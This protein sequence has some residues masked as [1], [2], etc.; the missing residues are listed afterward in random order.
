MDIVS[1]EKRSQ[2]MAGIR[3]ENT[4]SEM[5]IRKM[6]FARG[7]RYRLHAKDIFGK[8]D[9]VLKKYNATL[10]IHGCFWHGH[11]CQLF[12]LPKTRTEFWQNK[13]DENRKR[14]Q[15]VLVKLQDSGWRIA[16]VWEC[17]IRGK[18]RVNFEELMDKLCAWIQSDNKFVEY[19]GKQDDTTKSI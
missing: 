8:P 1:R 7:Y 10:F 4:K 17:A 19:A 16:I 13:I 5:M 18:N 9:L 11:T 6:L 2:M 14:D 12:K 15:R 3:S